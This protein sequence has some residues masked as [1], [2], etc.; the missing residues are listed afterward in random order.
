MYADNNILPK[1]SNFPNPISPIYPDVAYV[2]RINEVVE[3]NLSEVK[4]SFLSA[5]MRSRYFYASIPLT[6]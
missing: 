2:L 1:L 4:R 5:V 3:G 6:F